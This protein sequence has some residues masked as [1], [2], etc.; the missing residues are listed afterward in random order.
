MTARTA[1][2][3]ALSFCACPAFAQPAP[4]AAQSETASAAPRSPAQRPDERRSDKPFTV[5]WFGRPLE[6]GLSYET[7]AERRRNFDLNATSQRDRD[8]F[9]HELKLDARLRATDD[10]TAFVQGVALADRRKNK[11]DG[12]VVSKQSRERGQTWLLF[13]R[14]GGQPLALQAGRVA[15]IDRRSWW[16]DE[17]LDALRLIYMPG[18]WRVETGLARELARVSTAR[19]GIEPNQRGVTRWFGNTSLRWAPRHSVE[20]FWLLGQDRSGVPATGARF[21]DGEEDASDARLRWLGLRASGEHRFASDH[22]WTYR[23]DAALLRGREARTTFTTGPDDVLSAGATRTRRV[24][25][26]AWDIGTQWVLPGAARPTFSLGLANGSGGASDDTL[27]SNFRQT[28]L[29]ENK[30]RVAGVKRLRFYGELLDPELANLR[31][32]SAGFGLRFLANSSAE[33][34]WH[35]YRQ[36][37]ASTRIAGSRLSQDPAGLSPDIGREL[38]LFIAM[39]EWRQFELTLTLTRFMPGAAFAA[40]RRDPAHGVELGAALNF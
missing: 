21:A 28:G 5:D 18:D 25:G 4:A 40:D 34:L 35:R 14:I 11:R 10:V 16:W 9:D 29:Q 12:S 33:L 30:G 2:W 20:A 32:A 1:L 39:R 26:Q 36:R 3:L 13:E 27:D 19:R 38:D 23:A 17:D 24:R 31:I 22:R 8:V 7:S 15:L 37:Q 6:F